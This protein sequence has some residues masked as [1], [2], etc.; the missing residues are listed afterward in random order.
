MTKRWCRYVG[1][2]VQKNDAVLSGAKSPLYLDSRPRG[3]APLDSMGR[4]KIWQN[5]EGWVTNHDSIHNDNNQFQ[6]S[7]KN[8]IASQKGVKFLM[9]TEQCAGQH[10]DEK[11]D[12]YP[13]NGVLT[14]SYEPVI[15][16]IDGKKVE[17]VEYISCRTDNGP[18]DSRM[19]FSV[20]CQPHMFLDLRATSLKVIKWNPLPPEITS[21]LKR[22]LEG[23][24]HK[25]S[26]ARAA[27]IMEEYLDTWEPSS[28][29]IIGILDGNGE[30]RYAMEQVLIDRGIQKCNWP[31]IITFE[32]DAEV[33]LANVIMFPDAHFIYT[34]SD[35]DFRC[36]SE[37]NFAGENEAMV[38]HLIVKK[39]RLY[40]EEMKKRTKVF[41]FDYPGGPIGNKEPLKC[42]EYMKRVLNKL[43]DPQLIIG[44]TLSYRNH[45]GTKIPGLVP[46]DGFK[47]VEFFQHARVECGIYKRNTVD[48]DIGSIG[49][50]SD[51]SSGSSYG[52]S[53]GSSSGSS[54]VSSSVSS[55][56]TSSGSSPG[57]SSGSSPGSSSGAST[58]TASKRVRSNDVS[59]KNKETKKK[60]KEEF[61]EEQKAKLKLLEE[62]YNKEK[63][64]KLT[65]LEEEYNKKKTAKLTLLEEEY[66]KKKTE[67]TYGIAYVKKHW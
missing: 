12:Y 11:N 36:K 16:N 24:A 60:S 10:K 35:P 3:R 2:P 9:S 51:T 14:G 48:D 27:R 66:N 17:Y 55:S 31:E 57:S 13:F 61:I 15:K 54:S 37:H 44:V 4:S 6:L 43:N 50:D 19:N 1:D 33:A 26:M 42:Y 32:K 22:A 25:D 30:N 34:R 49:S 18:L 65:L 59:V 56:D 45:G 58:S 5:G 40:T 52:T 28:E 20:S 8:L 23:D 46:I 62:E 39:N 64:A 47:E 41:Y 63:T 67:L 21:T 38:E 53:S 29:H 7:L